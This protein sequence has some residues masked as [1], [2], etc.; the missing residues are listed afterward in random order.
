M[1]LLSRQRGP[2]LAREPADPEGYVWPGRSGDG[3]VTG[4]GVYKYLT[5]TIGVQTTIHGLRASFSSWCGNETNFDRVTCELALAHAA[6]SQ[7]EL[8]Y[9]R[10][11]ELT[12]RRDLMAAWAKYWEG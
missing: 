6:G 9:R 12:K 3:P 2:T 10:E 5:Q 11:D 1:M 8:A 4:K 7:V